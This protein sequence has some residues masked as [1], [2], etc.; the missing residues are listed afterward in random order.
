VKN[1]YKT[2]T[3]GLPQNGIKLTRKDNKQNMHMDERKLFSRTL[4][5]K[6]FENKSGN[7]SERKDMKAIIH[8]IILRRIKIYFTSFI[9]GTDKYYFLQ[10]N[11]FF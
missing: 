3:I 4:S 2:K 1:Y 6:L 8:N 11:S 10:K 7:E 9:K 5:V